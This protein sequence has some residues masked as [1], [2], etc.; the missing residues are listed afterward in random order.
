[1]SY[2]PGCDTRCPT[3]YT[4]YLISDFGISESL[5]VPVNIGWNG[6]SIAPQDSLLTLMGVVR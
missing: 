6:F 5:S 1:M 4:A 3:P 2:P